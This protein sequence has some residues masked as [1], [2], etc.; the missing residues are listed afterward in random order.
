MLT[1]SLCVWTAIHLNVSLSG[2]SWLKQTLYKLSWAVLGIVAPEIVLWRAT[3]QWLTA[4]KVRSEVNARLANSEE[5][6]IP[7]LLTSNN[8]GLNQVDT[9]R[10]LL[11]NTPGN[12]DTRKWTLMHGFF[13][14]MG[15]ITISTRDEYQ[16][17][18]VDGRTVTPRGVIALAEMDLLPNIDIHDI[19]A[20]SKS[21]QIAKTIVVLQAS[22]MLV[23]TIA[24]A[25]SG[26]PIT[27]LELNT[28][29]HVLC[30][31]FMYAIWWHK[32]QNVAEPLNIYLEQSDAAAIAI[33]S[34]SFLSRFLYI[35][36]PSSNSQVQTEH[37][38]SNPKGRRS[39]RNR[40][41]RSANEGFW[42]DPFL[43][44]N[45]SNYR[46]VG[47]ADYGWRGPLLPFIRTEDID[48]VRKIKAQT[49]P[50][51]LVMLLPGQS[52]ERLSFF[53]PLKDPVHMT[54]E[55]IERFELLGEL[56][57]YRTLPLNEE[58]R[59]DDYYFLCRK[60]SNFN[61]PGRFIGRTG[62][63]PLLPILSLIYGGVHATSWNGHFP[64]IAEKIMWRSSV[65]FVGVGGTLA[66]TLLYISVILVV[67]RESGEISVDTKWKKS[68]RYLLLTVLVVF[69]SGLCVVFVFGRV[70]I[71]VEAFISIR[72]LPVGAYDTVSWVG[73]L[74][75]FGG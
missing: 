22:W 38:H 8:S 65:C 29:A 74:P 58:L 17:I 51:G 30:A 34:P 5:A 12:S 33:A 61:V 39:K 43:P 31:V 6:A 50:D 57:G 62:V 48:Q 68:A 1:L 35:N 9:D 55:D 41:S 45:K 11:S 13:A 66:A 75:H 21:D 2:T 40:R 28:F 14:V 37:V 70:F 73:F 3:V 72:S 16:K 54:S 71:V 18:F 42:L 47:T 64:T 56:K 67:L 60:A 32:P 19:S 59:Q 23:Q 4:R 63:F 44:E 52:L 26:L 36:K 10:A 69:G 15:G 27:L 53:T 25:A 7:I 46:V 49:K 20:K 24:R